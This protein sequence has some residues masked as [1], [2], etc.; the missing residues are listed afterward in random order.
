MTH[1]GRPANLAF[2]INITE[3]GKLQEALLHKEKLEGIG[4][5]A[6]GIAHDIN[7]LLTVVTGTAD[8]LCLETDD[9]ALQEPQEDILEAAERCGDLVKQAKP[10]PVQQATWFHE[11]ARP[12]RRGPSAPELSRALKSPRCTT[13]C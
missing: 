2:M 1:N 5:L 13:A 3:S 10:P 7:N 12:M 9:K 8:L 11:A 4:K 6:G